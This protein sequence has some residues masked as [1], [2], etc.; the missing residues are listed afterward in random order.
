MEIVSLWQRLIS[1]IIDKILIAILFVIIAF[2]LCADSPGAE[3]GHF[4]SQLGI[5][6]KKIESEKTG[7]KLTDVKLS[8]QTCYR[9]QGCIAVLSRWVEDGS[10]Q[11][12]DF[13]VKVLAE[14][15]SNTEKVM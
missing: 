5:E 2:M 7:V 14:L 15:D 10:G 4:I 9:A 1:T 12:K 8:Y 13:I 6:Y 11:T 3:M